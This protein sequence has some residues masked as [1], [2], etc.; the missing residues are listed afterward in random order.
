MLGGTPP[1]FQHEILPIFQQ[2]CLGCHGERGQ[3]GV[4]LRNLATIVGRTG[5]SP[6][7][8]P[9]NPK[10]SLLLSV[11]ESG[12]MP[13]GGQP[14][15]P[16]QI[17]RIREWVAN[18][19]FPSADSARTEAIAKRIDKGRQFWS[20]RPP[21]KVQV[22]GPAA[23][24]IAAFVARK[25]ASK[26]L[27]LNPQETPERLVRRAYFDLV[28]L[29]PTFEEVKA[30][31]A[32][33][34]Q[35]AY[36]KLIDRLLASPQYGERWARH[37]LDVAGYA[38]SN[39]YLGDEPRTEAWRYRDWVIRALNDDKP[40]DQFLMEQFAGDQM[41][42]WRMGERLS[43][44]AIDKLIA[45]GFL[46][47]TPDGSDNQ[48]IYQLD[49]YYDAL[50]A[51]TE[52]S[53]K[54]ALGI[55]LNCARCHDHKF[56]PILQ[57]DYYRV[58]AFVSPAY[59][60]AKWLPANTGSGEWPSRFIP[61][62]TTAEFDAF[63]QKDKEIAPRIRARRKERSDLYNTFRQRWYRDKLAEASEGERLV[64]ENALDTPVGSRDEKTAEIVRQW[65]SRFPIKNEELEKKYPEVAAGLARIDAA[66]KADDEALD[67]VRPEMIWALWDVNKNAETRIL[68]RGSYLSPGD[69]VKPGIPRVLDATEKPFAVPEADAASHST[70]R[71]LAFAKWLTSPSNPLTARVIV[72]RVW[73][74]HFG[75]GLVRTPDDFG[76]QGAR[77]THPEL[78]DWLAVD[79]ME[80][81]WS[82]KRLHRQ[83]M[84]SAVYKQ[85]ATASP[86]KIA[87]D[88]DNKLLARRD[89]KRL[90]AEAIRDSLLAVSGKLNTTLY[91]PPIALCK[92]PDGQF[93]ADTSGRIDKLIGVP[94]PPCG[95]AT[96][97]V[98]AERRPDR[99]SIY[100]QT[101]RTATVS[102]LNAFDMP[103]M[104]TNAAARFRSTVPSQS[105]A[106]MHNPL[107]LEAAK[108]LASRAS[109]ATTDPV[110]WVRR[111]FELAYARA[112][113]EQEVSVGYG[114]VRRADDPMAGF[115][116]FCQ[117]LLASNEFIYVD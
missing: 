36:A 98:P 72:N 105:L 70:G 75:D 3:G 26:G 111:A 44:A 115:I 109:S 114:A 101:K 9:G 55:N 93:F 89:P 82:L 96:P 53:V 22:P 52:V 78:L 60:P 106:L 4:D 56:D 113:G 58:M 51:T 116:R 59:D 23:D 37:W 50:H 71:R 48:K 117:A 95:E 6:L 90:E 66:G 18:G 11:I 41:V 25:A 108:G 31:G 68:V 86:E 17:E 32:D 43:P 40:Y 47:M 85:S 20:F 65:E 10:G 30:F 45:T 24:P 63:I 14:L 29:P 57:E 38:D 67:A 39:G 91:G 103:L 61:N 81:G 1:T 112:S 16:D 69:P 100:L 97:E 8:V 88:P 73:Q 54:A 2:S 64:F 77:P 21:I 74:F 19:Q 80:N 76:T 33:R 46:R 62:A 102:L 79:F 87:A 42:S 12:K 13:K 84:L 107:V 99:R 110:A 49:K 104:E 7:V 34:D 27:T 94:I 92:G 5:G 15:S 35:S 28:G 83:I